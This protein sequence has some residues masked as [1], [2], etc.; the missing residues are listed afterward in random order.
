MH[1]GAWLRNS[2]PPR[3]LWWFAKLLASHFLLLIP[4]GKKTTGETTSTISSS[5]PKRSKQK[6]LQPESNDFKLVFI[7]SDS[8]KDSDQLNSSLE[9]GPESLVQINNNNNNS[10][11]IHDDM[12]FEEDELV[13]NPP[14]LPPK[15]RS[16]NNRNLKNLNLID[17]MSMSGTSG[18]SIRTAATR[19]RH[20]PLL[21]S[22]RMPKVRNIPVQSSAGNS[23]A[24]P[25]IVDDRSIT[26]MSIH[27]MQMAMHHDTSTSILSRSLSESD[28]SEICGNGHIG[29]ATGSG[30]HSPIYMMAPSDEDD[31]TGKLLS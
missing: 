19:D 30:G 2:C 13:Q 14:D 21:R 28:L 16:S 8:S 29:G 12:E 31:N 5:S 7:S 6:L 17:R 20:S 11:F 4:L 1:H 25:S 18:T 27:D 24:P 22:P 26:E 10:E 9:N 3:P 15:T 23:L